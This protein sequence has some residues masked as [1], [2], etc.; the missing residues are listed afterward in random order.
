MAANQVKH[1]DGTSFADAVASGVGLVDF[2]APWCWPCRMQ[3]P[4]LDQV[5]EAIGDSA[6]IAKVNVDEAPG[7]ASQFG[8]SS[9]PTMIVLKDGQVVEQF[10]GIQQ[11]DTL[12]RALRQ[13]GVA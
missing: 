9:I 1:L 3:G 6:T 10:V 2:W 7:V 12:L 11:A 13:A 8:I 5:A 4:I